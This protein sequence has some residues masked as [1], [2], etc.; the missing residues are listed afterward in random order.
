[1]RELHNFQVIAPAKC[2]QHIPQL[3]GL[4]VRGGPSG[5]G[6]GEPVFKSSSSAT[7]GS[8]KKRKKKRKGSD[9]KK[10]KKRKKEG[11]KR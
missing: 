8:A 11:K 1:M 4:A 9:A 6:S 3:S 2:I 7:K 5:Y 10:K